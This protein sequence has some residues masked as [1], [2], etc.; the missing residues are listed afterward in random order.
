MIIFSLDFSIFAWRNY[1][2]HTM[3]FYIFNETVV[4]IT[5]IGKNITSIESLYEFANLRTIS[6]GTWCDNHSDRHTM[7]IHSQMYL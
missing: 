6:N 5:P 7:R 3:F 1:C 2:F 4:V